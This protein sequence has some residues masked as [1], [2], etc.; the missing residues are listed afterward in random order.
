MR[1][2]TLLNSSY[3]AL[4]SCII[5][6]SFKGMRDYGPKQMAVRE[7]V[8]NIITEI[9]QKHGAVQISTPVM[10]LRVNNYFL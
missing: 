6:F 5:L 10:E 3:L 4:S 2:K 9:F 8:F 1:L 7:K